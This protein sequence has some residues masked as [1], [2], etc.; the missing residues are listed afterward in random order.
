VP[1][2]RLPA[3]SASYVDRVRV[4]SRL[5]FSHPVASVNAPTPIA[6]AAA[7]AAQFLLFLI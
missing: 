5:L 1:V 3:T 7:R 4:S 6:A 2:E